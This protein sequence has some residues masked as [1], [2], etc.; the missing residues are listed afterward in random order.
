MHTFHD[1]VVP[2]FSCH[3]LEE[4]EEEL[5]LKATFRPRREPFA[6]FS[7]TGS[8]DSAKIIPV[9]VLRQ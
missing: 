2:C 4:D 3:K 9:T 5:S 1:A 7:I 8:H 6:R